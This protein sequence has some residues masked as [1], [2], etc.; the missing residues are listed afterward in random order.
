MDPAGREEFLRHFPVSHETLE[1][2]DRYA[3]LLGEWNAKFNLI[4]EKS[5]PHIWRRHFLDC[6]QLIKFIPESARSIADLGSGAGLPGIVLSIL[7]APQVHLIEST[8]KKANFLREVINELKLNAIVRQ[9]RIESLHNIR[10]DVITARA[11]K[12]LPQLLKLSKPLINK[13][14]LCLFL[15]GQTVHS[16]LTEACKLWK[17]GAEIFPSLSDASGQ[18]LKI[19]NLQSSGKKP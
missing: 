13:D 6:A 4:G 16:E 1:K 8:G 9:M 18:V 2:L 12:P 11:L 14:S 15:K 5:L 7:G 19:C 17:F 10:F 3:E